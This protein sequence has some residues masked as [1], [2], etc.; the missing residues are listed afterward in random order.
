MPNNQ[1]KKVQYRVVK[2]NIDYFE[3]MCKSKFILCPAGD[4]SW[5]FRFYEVLMCKSI[6]IVESWHHTYR[7]REEADFNYK[8]VLYQDIENDI[9]CDDYV[10][11][12][13]NIFENNHLL[14]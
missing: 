7:T 10:N 8:Y 5:S 9:I 4:S 1:S 14:K 2:E 3:K 6:P 12:N 13:T 11:I